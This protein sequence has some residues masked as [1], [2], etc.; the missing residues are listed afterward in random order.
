MY[1][2]YEKKTMPLLHLPLPSLAFLDVKF[3][4]PHSFQDSLASFPKFSPKLRRFFIRMP[5]LKDTFSTIG[6]NYICRWRNLCSL[7]CPQVALDLNALAHLTQM[8]ALTRLTFALSNTLPASDSPH[9]F[10]NLHEL[11][12]HSKS[13]DPISQLF[14]QTRLPVITK[15]IAHIDNS[16]SKQEF[17]SFFASIPP[18]NADHTIKSLQLTQTIPMGVILAPD[19]EPPSLGLEDLRP[20]MV[21]GDLRHIELNIKCHIGLTDSQLLTLA[22]AWPKL[23]DLLINADWGWDS[24]R[25]ITLDGLVRLLQ[26]CRSLRGF[27]L[28]LDTQGYTEW[29]PSQAPASLGLTFPPGFSIDVVDSIIAP[30]SVSAVAT[31]FSGIATCVES[32]FCFRAWDGTPMARFEGSEGF[33]ERW[34][35]VSRQLDDAMG[36]SSDSGG[37]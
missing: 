30:E 34:E 23:E 13:L 24:P 31:F 26:S 20:C 19:S 16:P 35:D 18:S 36:G 21:F 28:A 9:L 29:H 14:S 37:W 17:A 2:E 10:S 6:P 5:Q 3:E 15:I 25:G 1:C 22:S 33:I 4:S 12:L 11:T 7:I 8:P 27:A 32:G